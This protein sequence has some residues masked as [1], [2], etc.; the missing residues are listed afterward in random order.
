MRSLYLCRMKILMVC[1]GNICRSPLA[2]GILRKKTADQ[3]LSWII[4][5]AGTNGYHTGEAP[6]HL[7]QK[8]AKVNGIDIS[9]QVSRKF[10]P[11]DFDHYDLIY[12]MADDVYQDI[13]KMSGQKFDER[14]I[15]FFLEELQGVKADVPDPWY[16][17]EDGYID[18]YKLIDETCDAI[19]KNT[20]QN[21]EKS[22][23]K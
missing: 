20:L 11:A 14:K 8:V 13:K 1:L 4:D 15:K 23:T 22:N 18:V 21:A 9:S 19:I 5:S 7:S 16:G 3:A 2:E 6:H 10:T 12:V 17:D